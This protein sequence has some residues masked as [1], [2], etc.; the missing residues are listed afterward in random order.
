MRRFTERQRNTYIT[1]RAKRLAKLHRRQAAQLHEIVKLQFRQ[2]A[3]EIA[4][5]VERDR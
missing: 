3:D 5:K 1:R 2:I 4:Q